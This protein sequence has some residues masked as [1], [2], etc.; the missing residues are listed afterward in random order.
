VRGFSFLLVLALGALSPA[1]QAGEKPKS[2]KQAVK[3]AKVTDNLNKTDAEWKKELSDEQFC[4]LRQKATE[5]AFSGKYNDH[6]EKG[7]YKC[8]ACGAELFGSDTKFDSR[9]GWP[10]YFAPVSS[11]AVTEKTDNDHGMQR[12]EV[13]CSRC[14]GHLGHVFDD[15]PKPTGLRYCINSASLNFEKK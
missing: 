10:S 4:I 3:E 6:H 12:T 1:A 7:V 13:I 2:K 8:A 9:S 14:G 15:G 11:G 5:R